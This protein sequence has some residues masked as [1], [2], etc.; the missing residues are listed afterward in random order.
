[1]NETIN[2]FLSTGD[3]FLPEM[4]LRQ[5]GFTQSA[6]VSFTKKQR[7]NK[8]FKQRG[9]LRSIQENLLDKT[10][11]QHDMAY[12]NFEDLPKRTAA[13]K[14]LCYEAVYIAK[15]PKYDGY[16]RVLTS[17]TFKSFDKKSS[18]SCVQSEVIP[19]EELDE[20]LHKL[21]IRKFVKRKYIHVLKTTFEVLILRPIE[22][23]H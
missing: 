3:K 19:N 11:F 21:I 2:M 15:N 13:D 7:K 4:H 16:Q 14:V 17:V 12:G 20:E 1:M 6:C 9:Y 22:F 5:P 10:C 8:S 18:G 23:L